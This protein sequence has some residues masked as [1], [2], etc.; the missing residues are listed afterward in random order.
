MLG[1]EEQAD[2]DKSGDYESMYI[3]EM[4]GARDADSVPL[5]RCTHH[6]GDV[7]GVILR[8]PNSIARNLDRS[9]SDPFAAWRTPIVEVQ[10]RVVVQDR[11]STADQHHYK[12]KVE[13]MARA[14]LEREAVR[15]SEIT[16]IDLWDW[17]NL[18][19]A[20]DCDFN[21]RCGDRGDEHH[22]DADQD[23][24]SN[25]DPKPPITWIVHCRVRRI[26]RDHG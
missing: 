16:W 20:D 17:R 5:T 9:E 7:A 22:R 21:P 13:E 19:Q 25:P 15:P 26:E 11:K 12:E 3:D 4:P 18:G 8:R 23:R 10:P 2:E 14:Y 24:R 1:G 6:R